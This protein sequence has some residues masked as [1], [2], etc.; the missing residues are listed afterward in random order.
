VF[1]RKFLQS[2]GFIGLGV[3]LPVSAVE[4]QQTAQRPNQKYNLAPVTIKGKVHRKGE[5]IA[6]VA[7]TDGFNIVLTDKAGRYVL[8]SNATAEFVYISIPRGYAFPHDK[9]IIRFY[10]SIKS[11]GSSLTADFELQKLN[12]DDYFPILGQALPGGE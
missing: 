10:H 4:A 6:G 11:G 5:G 2:L 9:G 12:V 8:N 7:V 3:G 1:R